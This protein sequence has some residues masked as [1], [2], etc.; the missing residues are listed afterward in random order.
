MGNLYT[1]YHAPHNPILEIL[2]LLKFQWRSDPR[3][4]KE[5]NRLQKELHKL[6]LKN[7]K[8]KQNKTFAGLFTWKMKEK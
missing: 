2:Q 3:N 8:P 7:R 1:Q 6:E 5:I 4:Y